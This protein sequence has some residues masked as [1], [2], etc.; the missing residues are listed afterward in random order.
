MHSQLLFK[1][2]ISDTFFSQKIFRSLDNS[3]LAAASQLLCLKDMNNKNNNKSGKKLDNKFLQWFVG[4]TD[5][6]GTFLIQ[7]KIN[8][9]CFAASE[10]AVSFCFKITL[11]IDD[12]A[13]LFLIKDIL[14]IGVVSIKGNTCTFAVHSF[15]LI[16]EVLL[17]IF[18]KYPLITHKQLNY[19]D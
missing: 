19:R 6:E 15:Q 12:S 4:F 16:V 11:H 3:R 18:D 17:P 2:V 1:K 10:T 7:T 9:S 14:G 8:S 13:V 5:S